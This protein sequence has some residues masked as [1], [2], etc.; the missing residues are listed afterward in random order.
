M[1][2]RKLYVLKVVKLAGAE[3]I[4]GPGSLAP[5]SMISTLLSLLWTSSILP[6]IWFVEWITVLTKMVQKHNM[7]L[8][9]TRAISWRRGRCG[10]GYSSRSHFS[11]GVSQSFGPSI[12]SNTALDLWIS[13]RGRKNELASM[14]LGNSWHSIPI[15]KPNNFFGR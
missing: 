2:H 7:V 15:W 1:K 6:Y 13:L 11:E 4:L 12:P 8:L 9:W 14:S 3:P 10:P 5:K